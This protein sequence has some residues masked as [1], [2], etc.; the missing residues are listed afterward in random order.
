MFTKTKML[1]LASLAT[2]NIATCA[3]AGTPFNATS[4]PDVYSE[5]VSMAGLDLQTQAG[6][7]IALHRIRAAAHQV[8]EVGLDPYFPGVSVRTKPCTTT[9][10]DRAVAEVDSPVLTALNSD[11]GRTRA[12]LAVEGR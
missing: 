2:A 6:A 12:Q 3:S 1:L 11:Q 5:K 7:E 8:C 4:D 9:A 10:I